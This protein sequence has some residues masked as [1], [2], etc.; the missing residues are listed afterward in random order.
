V[1][2][3]FSADPTAGQLVCT[4]SQGSRD[5]TLLKE[6]AYQAVLMLI[7]VRFDAPLPWTNQNL[8]AW[9]ASAI[10][11]VDFRGDAQLS[12]CCAPGGVVVIQTSNLYVLTAT[13]GAVFAAV[14][15]LTAL[16]IHEARHNEGY[17]HTCTTGERAGQNDNTIAELGAWGVQYYFLLWLGN[18]ANPG[19]LSPTMRLDSTQEAESMKTRFF[20]RLSAS[21]AP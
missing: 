8:D 21:P 2:L 7:W 6:R 9:W 4:A 5:L 15:G 20:C 3:A 17:L 10:H 18:H 14:R 1:S 16:Y 12:Y 11:G 19:L 13:D